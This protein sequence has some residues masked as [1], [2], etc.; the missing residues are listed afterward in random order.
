MPVNIMKKFKHSESGARGW[1]IGNFPKAII[2]SEHFE[3][4]WQANPA[5]KKDKPHYHKKA[6]EI[7][8]V[9][10]GS[11]IINDEIFNVGDICVLDPG[12]HY[13]AEYLE[14]T[15]VFAIKTPSMPD[16]KYYI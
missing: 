3:C 7:Q 11:M 9:V 6:T 1:F 10:K 4:C 2:Q 15:E 13:Y 16:D 5:G 14:D 8:L 12:E